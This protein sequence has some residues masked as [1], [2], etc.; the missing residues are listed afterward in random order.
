MLEADNHSLLV[1]VDTNRPDQV[2]AE[3]LLLSC[4]K[5]AV[6]DHHRRSASYIE[7]AALNY[8]E[9]YASSASKLVTEL[10]QYLMESSDL[11]RGEAEALLAGIVLDTKSF[12]LRTGGRTFEAAAF[13]RRSGADT[14][15]VKR[16]FQTNL[17][18]TIAKY[19]IISNARTYKN[20]VVVAA[21]DH[22]VG[23]V[24][25]AQGPTSC[26]MWR[27]PPPALCS[28]PT[29]EPGVHLRPQHRR[30]QRPGDSGGPG[31]RQRRRRS[32][33]DRRQRCGAGAPAA[34][35]GG[36]PVHFGAEDED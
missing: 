33:P 5:V 13:L 26:S 29:A 7:N 11:L 2:V 28:S 3:Q 23:R 31:R 4:N 6:I 17:S 21:M 27:A 14:V 18:D 25:A 35:A 1:V 19:D 10:L 12:T 20:G 36:G 15:E 9:P 34:A 8:H 32:S 22:P 16:L 30:C 24:T